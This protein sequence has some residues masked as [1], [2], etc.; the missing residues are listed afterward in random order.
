MVQI[1]GAQKLQWATRI[2]KLSLVKK[3]FESSKS[4]ESILVSAK[5]ALFTTLPECDATQAN[6]SSHMDRRFC[7]N[8]PLLLLPD[9]HYYDDD[10]HDDNA[11]DNYGGNFFP[12]LFED[13][14]K[15]SHV[16]MG[17]IIHL[18]NKPGSM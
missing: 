2:G 12:H 9:D 10:S 6:P 4:P 8:S 13:A 3:T 11:W 16:Q 5:F 18:H 17:V 15:M 14:Y 1:A 7:W